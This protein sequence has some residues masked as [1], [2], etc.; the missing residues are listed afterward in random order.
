MQNKRNKTWPKLNCLQECKEISNKNLQ[1]Q[2]LQQRKRK[3]KEMNPNLKFIESLQIS[4]NFTDNFNK[5]YKEKE[6]KTKPQFQNNL[7]FQK[8]QDLNRHSQFLKQLSSLLLVKSRK[9]I[10]NVYNKSQRLLLL[11]NSSSKFKKEGNK[12]RKKEKKNNIK[13][14]SKRKDYKSMKI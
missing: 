3:L 12:C 11:Q 5:A 1:K 13:K 8:T 10:K 9:I 6:S 14:I 2:H 7:I 4:K